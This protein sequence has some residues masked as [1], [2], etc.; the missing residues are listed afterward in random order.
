MGANGIF[1]SFTRRASMPVGVPAYK[2]LVFGSIDKKH[3]AIAIAGLICPPVPPP[4]IN[5]R[6]LILLFMCYGFSI[7]AKREILS[8]I[9][10]SPSC[11]IIAVPP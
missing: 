2:S 4:V 10:I 8:K 9:P 5:T 7:F 3:W 11:I 6:I 1:A